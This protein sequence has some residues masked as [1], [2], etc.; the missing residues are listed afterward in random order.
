MAV[1]EFKPVIRQ[2][3]PIQRE[4][5]AERIA[6][7]GWQPFVACSFCGD[8]G[9]DPDTGRECEVCVVGTQ[10]IKRASLEKMWPT[11]IPRRFVN[12]TLED[13]PNSKLAQDVGAW[14]DSNP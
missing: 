11:I 13:H 5:D 9:H 10:L 1:R 6:R 2:F 7:H 3:T 4:T 12:Y 8:T 14:I